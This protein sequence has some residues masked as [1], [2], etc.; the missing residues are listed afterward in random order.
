MGRKLDGL[1][2]PEV[3]GEGL[4]AFFARSAWLEAASVG[5]FRRLARELRAH[6]APD[7]LIAAAKACALDEIRHARL[8]ARLAKKHGASVPRVVVEPSGKASTRR[9]PT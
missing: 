2:A 4:A 8:M 1:S 5:A 7:E 3:E 9:T 6:G